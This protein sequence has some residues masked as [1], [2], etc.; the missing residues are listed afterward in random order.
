MPAG[1]ATSFKPRAEILN[2]AACTILTQVSQNASI[3]GVGGLAVDGEMVK[4][5][6][7]EATVEEAQEEGDCETG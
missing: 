6:R 5:E 2:L 3:W 1:C 7:L 4:M